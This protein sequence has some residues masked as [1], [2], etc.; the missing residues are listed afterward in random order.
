MQNLTQQ[1][2]AQRLRTLPA[3]LFER[4]LNTI[5]PLLRARWLTRQRPL[6]AVIAWA[7]TRY[8]AVLIADGS[9]LDVSRRP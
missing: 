2:L 3:E 5:L 6:P 7:Q 4:V 1:A 9:T 8:T